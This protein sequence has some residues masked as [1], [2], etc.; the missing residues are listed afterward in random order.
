MVLAS[1]LLALPVVQTYLASIV[2][3]DINTAYKT[4][5]LVDKVDLSYLGKIQLKG[6]HI[7]D[8]HQKPMIDVANFSTSIFSYKKAYNNK[9]LFDAV[10]LSGVN[11]K[12]VT[13]K[14]ETNDN[15]SIFVE[16][17]DEEVPTGKPS[18]FLLTAKNIN[19]TN[20]NFYLYDHNFHKKPLAFYK[21]LK[22]N[23]NQFKIQGPN[24]STKIR[25]LQ[26]IEDHNLEVI[27]FDTDF[28]YTLTGMQFHNSKIKT[29][30][31]AVLMDL[32]FDYK[33]KN[34][35]CF[36]DSVQVKAVFKKSLLSVQDLKHFYDGLDGTAHIVLTTEMEGTLNDLKL[37]NL[38]AVTSTD[39]KIKGNVRL[40]SSFKYIKPF[41]LEADIENLT[42]NSNQ[43]KKLL[44]NLLGNN[45]PPA[46]DKLGRFSIKGKTAV[47]KTNI[48][49]KSS[50]DSEIGRINLNMDFS[51]I[52]DVDFTKYKGTL[53]LK[54]F[55][56]GK[57]IIDSLVGRFSMLAYING[58]GFVKKNLNTAFRAKITKHQYKGYTY[59]DVSVEGNFKHNKF[60]GKLVS[61]DPNLKLTISGSADFSK[62]KNEYKLKSDVTYANFNEL[63][64]F[65]K[66]IVSILKGGISFNFKGNTLDELEGQINFKDASYTNLEDIYFFKDFIIKS[67]F[68]DS[69]RTIGI[70][71]TDIISGKLKGNFKL[72]EL[73]N[74][75]ENGLGSLLSKYNFKAV[76]PNQNLDY[77]FKIY[78]KIIE[79]FYP[80][81]KVAPST[82]L[83][84]SLKT[85]DN[86]FSLN[87]KSPQ[88]DL[89]EN[90]IQ[91]INL[92]VDNK[93]PLFN[94]LLSV[95]KINSSY[96]NISKIN[97]VNVKLKDTLFMRT[98]FY[99]GDSLTEKYSLSMYNTK[100]KNGKSVFGIKKSSINVKN[101]NWELNPTNNKANKI[102]FDTN[103]NSFTIEKIDLQSGNQ[104]MNVAGV[105]SGKDTKDIQVNLENVALENITPDID[106]LSLKGVINGNLNYK[107]IKGVLR[108]ITDVTIDNF[109]VNNS[110]Q[111]NVI[112]NAQGFN[113][114]K[115]YE[116]NLLIIRND[117]RSLYA[118]GEVDLTT[119]KPKLD[120]D[121]SLNKFILNAFSPLGENVLS[122]IR[123]FASGHAKVTGNLGNPFID[124]DLVLQ[125]AGLKFPYI[126]VDYHFKGEPKIKLYKHTF[127][128]L[129]TTLVDETYKTEASLTGTISHE[130]LKKWF[131]D[132]KLKTNNLL[133][134]NTLDN[135]ETLYYGTGFINGQASITGITDNLLIEVNGKT[136][137]G[138]RFIIP[139][140]DVRSIDNSNLIH[141]VNKETNPNKDRAT[142][143]VVLDKLQG[144]N[145]RFNLDVTKDAVAQ[146]VIDKKTG[147]I[148]KGSGDGNLQISINTN[149]NFTMFGNFVVD[150]GV[151]QFKN[152]I[153]KSFDVSKGGTIN[154]TGNPY[155]ADLDIEAIYHTK[156]NP[157]VLLENFRGTR[158]VDVDLITQIDGKLYESNIQFDVKIPN[159]SS[160]VN[161]E[162]QFKLND[163]DK[164]M[165]QFFSL[166]TT[167]MFLNQD[168]TNFDSNAALT[169]TLSERISSILSDVLNKE[170]SQFQ[171]GV[172]YDVGVGDKLNNLKTDDQLEIS[173][174]SKISKKF[175]ING[176]VG[177]P[178]GS[179][180]QSSVVGEVEIA[181]PLNKSESLQ[182]RI[183]NRQNQ[184]QFAVADEEGYTQGLG[185][186]YKIEFDS[187]KDLFKKLKK[188]K[189]QKTIKKD[190]LKLKNGHLQFKPKQKDS[191]PK[192]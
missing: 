62:R 86:S 60:K 20:A 101:I 142:E 163:S 129:P 31:S 187:G 30:T 68:K 114:F 14:D 151:Y 112:F 138:T 21:H 51:D 180:T 89:F 121:I 57:V 108:P 139:L 92:Q 97:L 149:G 136:N 124:G 24:V 184:I 95:S 55:D 171:I 134:L 65:K 181:M 88:L 76:T 164:K 11:I 182:A 131:L 107:Q 172:N 78:N 26:F 179:K 105:I 190:S 38:E 145:I 167:G 90:T 157:A 147:S 58:K 99:G 143:D 153:N 56:L 47:T 35:R 91:D 116:L 83:K 127:E 1:L 178:V 61:A 40:I 160:N 64:L 53:G 126:N 128:F 15:I 177:V 168:N 43:L 33:R 154:W 18:G 85:D 150:N 48:K 34:L 169:G 133:V 49:T 109:V 146:I 144:L 87:F 67:H 140:S 189:K 132:L 27:Q 130:Y 185:L 137:A 63:N 113:T 155:N 162:L 122:N 119:D 54:N 32:N 84:G 66:D 70:N 52:G 59:K 118:K 10:K 46:L 80:E 41:K 25:H 73:P 186:S 125:N 123:G 120:I 74:L 98:N 81:I 2:T 75:V 79:V 174:S 42:A 103:F 102:I 36:Y 166:L 17:F 110:Y 22:G 104:K 159:A 29:K 165:T 111:G 82:F 161:S 117:V 152:I 19:L 175:T 44:P 141:F 4:A 156:A 12:M 170:G 191:I 50:I 72:K 9:I 71:S 13:Y 96:Y 8:H 115:K 100:A 7:K 94:T 37:N 176:K 69:I 39:V 6:I 45:L 106:S 16:K 173:V 135:D 93:N 192:N 158:N 77:N 28:K 23:L 188:K 183:F 3:R 5:I 148:L